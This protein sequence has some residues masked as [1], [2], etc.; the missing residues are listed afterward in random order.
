MESVM[1]TDEI[2]MIVDLIAGLGAAGKDAFIWWLVIKYLL[3]YL[4]TFAGIMVALTIAYKLLSQGIV[5]SDYGNWLKDIRRI[6]TPEH[7]GYFDKDDQI[8]IM[9]SLRENFKP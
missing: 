6:V 9:D 1:N 8:R 3:C 4:L 7:T 2:K 5:A